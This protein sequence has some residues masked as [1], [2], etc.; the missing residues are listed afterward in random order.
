VI[1]THADSILLKV[2]SQKTRVA[3]R[4]Q[5]IRVFARGGV[6]SR[7]VGR[8]RLH[9]LS[10]SG[11]LSCEDV[12][13][14]PLL[15]LRGPLV[16]WRPG[17]GEPDFGAL[18]WTLEKRWQAPL[19]TTRVYFAGREG[20]R[21]YGGVARGQLTNINQVS[22]DL[23]VTEVY[24]RL[25]AEEPALAA[26]WVG[27]DEHGDT[28]LKYQKQPD[29]V[30]CDDDGRPRLAIEFGGLYGVAKLSAFHRDMDRR[31]LPYEI[32]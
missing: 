17:Y 8:R 12:P 18:A 20:L 22:H 31:G 15:D 10:A 3:T 7:R 21:L 23:H 6:T 11:I 5:A 32:W 1:L 14:R 26:A 4:E 28:R 24:L 9:A 29:A 13:A 19:A 25:L 16:C 27:E 2:L 30:L